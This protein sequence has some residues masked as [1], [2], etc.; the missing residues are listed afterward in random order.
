[1][2]DT[3][4]EPSSSAPDK[5]GIIYF[6]RVPPYVSPQQMRAVLERYGALGR[7]YLT[8]ES[9]EVRRARR[10]RGG[11][12]RRNFT[13]GWVEFLDRRVARVCMGWGVAGAVH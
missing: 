8:P 12:A 2:A 6:A 4:E 5:P 11:S 3:T 13:D 9:D 1:M 10:R 7:V